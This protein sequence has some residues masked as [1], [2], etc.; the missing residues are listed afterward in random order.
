M[1]QYYYAVAGML[2]LVVMLLI[3]RAQKAKAAKV[4]ETAAIHEGWLPTSVATATPDTW[5]GTVDESKR[6]TRARVRAE[7]KAT[8]KDAADAKAQAKAEA[9]ADAK[10]AKSGVPAPV[11]GIGDEPPARAKG[12]RRSKHS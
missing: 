3:M 6:Q 1:P 5:A 7:A 9:K 11:D 8:A 4:D 10:A 2:V 12:H